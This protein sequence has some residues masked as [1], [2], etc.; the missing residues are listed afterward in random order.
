MGSRKK[1]SSERRAWATLLTRDQYAVG[2]VTLGRS[3]MSSGTAY[4]LVVMVTSAVSSHTLTSFAGVPG[5]RVEHV[6]PVD[7]GPSTSS[8]KD[9][10]FERFAEVWTKL[11]A[12]SLV[13][14]DKVCFLDSDMLVLRH[15]DDVFDLVPGHVDLA[16]CPAC[17]CN[18]NRLPQY[19]KSW[20]PANCAFT[21][22]RGALASYF[23]SG[24]LVLCPSLDTLT[25]LTTALAA[26]DR[27]SYPFA[28]QD[29]LNEYFAESTFL[30]PYVYNAL[31]T[32]IVSHPDLWDISDV[33][34]I[35]Y[36]L[37][38]PWDTNPA[39]SDPND[40]YDVVNR[41]WWR[42]HLC[43]NDSN[44]LAPWIAS[45]LSLL[46]S[47]AAS[48]R[49]AMHSPASASRSSATHCSATKTLL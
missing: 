7:P 29:F 5:M 45:P 9:Y 49:S 1:E 26:A 22:E 47:G 19:P 2:T 39:Q 13:D 21:S 10:A 28:D 32:L 15:M 27:S 3:L 23:N 44:V 41:M 36:V 6:D 38:K 46:P 34:N 18:Q 20:V 33:R 25:S 12:W 4:P 17:T 40:P 48:P 37:Q 43:L 16:A 24:L 35:H 31:K 30:L 42:V 14:Y 8:R 11:Q